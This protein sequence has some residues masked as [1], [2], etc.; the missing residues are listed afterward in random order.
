MPSA[1]YSLETFSCLDVVYDDIVAN[2]TP[3]FRTFANGSD[4]AYKMP[5]A[6]DEEEYGTIGDMYRV[7]AYGYI[8][9]MRTLN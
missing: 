5:Q 3:V 4:I 1:V 7:A 2:F 6:I 8:L 9:S